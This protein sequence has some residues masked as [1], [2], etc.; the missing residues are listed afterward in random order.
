M[1][2]FFPSPR[3]RVGAKRRP[4]TGS[5]GRGGEPLARL[6]ASVAREDGRKRS[7]NVAHYELSMTFSRGLFGRRSRVI[8]KSFG[9]QVSHFDAGATAFPD[10]LKWHWRLDL[11]TTVEGGSHGPAHGSP[12]GASARIVRD[13]EVES[14]ASHRRLRAFGAGSAAHAPTSTAEQGGA[15]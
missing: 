9:R 15:A 8:S 2:L 5:A 1:G 3:Q 7:N 4:M 12:S 6:R 13:N 10:S 14:T 11:A